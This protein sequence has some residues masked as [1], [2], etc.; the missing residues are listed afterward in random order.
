MKIIY[1]KLMTSQPIL[2][3]NRLKLRPFVP[4]DAADVQSMAGDY[5]VAKMTLNIPHPYSSGTAEKWISTHHK[6]WESRERVTWAVCFSKDDKL[7]GCVG[8]VIRGR[9]TR[10]VERIHGRLCVKDW[11]FPAPTGPLS[12]FTNGKKYESAAVN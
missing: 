5:R 8:L 1:D 11:Q 2:E 9:E 7:I 6:N 3:T 4:S 12:C 10:Q